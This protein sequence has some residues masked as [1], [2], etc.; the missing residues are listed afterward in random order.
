LP[1]QHLEGVYIS[2]EVGSGGRGGALRGEVVG[3]ENAAGAGLGGHGVCDC[4]SVVPG[5]ALV[6]EAGVV[7]GGGGW[8]ANGHAETLIS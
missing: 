6:A 4:A 3:C 2:E 7:L 8:A 1:S 5:H